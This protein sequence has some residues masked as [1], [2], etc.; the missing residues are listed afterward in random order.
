MPM[1]EKNNVKFINHHHKQCF[2]HYAMRT[3]VCYLE[4]IVGYVVLT[5]TVQNV[6]FVG[7]VR[8]D[9]CFVALK[10]KE[11]VG[12]NFKASKIR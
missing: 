3:C 1:G 2:R 10:I 12:K 8:C 7:F 4:I 6:C 5:C 9:A 11:T